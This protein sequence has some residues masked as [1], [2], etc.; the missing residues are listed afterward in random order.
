MLVEGGLVSFRPHLH[1]RLGV[2]VL[3]ESGVGLRRWLPHLL[4]HLHHFGM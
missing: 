4:P 3:A 2:G 1:L